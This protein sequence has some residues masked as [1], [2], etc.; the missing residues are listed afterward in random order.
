MPDYEALA[1]AVIK[2]KNSLA[3][4]LTQAALDEGAA[5]QEI[6]EKGLIAGMDVVGKKFKAN[7]YYIPEVLIS[8]RAMKAGVTLLKPFLAEAGESADTIRVVAGTVMGD[9]HDIGKNLVVMMLEGAGFRVVDAGVDCSPEKFVEAIKESNAHV[10]CLS[11][12]LTTTL[13]S[14]KDTIAAIEEAGLRNDVKVLIGGAPVTQEYSDEIGADGYA[15][16][17]ASGVD[18]VKELMG[19]GAAA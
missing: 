7:E 18:K 1:E 2:G 3:E 11:A 12:L 6:L 5:A 19:S 15:P 13:P 9:L 17:A 10:V 16:D 4:E 14:M 8:A